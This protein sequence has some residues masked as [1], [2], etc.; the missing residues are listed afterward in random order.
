ME[1]LRRLPS[2]F[3]DTPR[4]AGNGRSFFYASPYGRSEIKDMLQIK[5]VYVKRVNPDLQ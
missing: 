4:L 2:E 3:E 5:N 1:R